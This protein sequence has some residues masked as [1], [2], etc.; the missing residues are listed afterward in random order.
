MT[1]CAISK[2]P[3][4]GVLLLDKP[5]G[6]TSNAALQ[7]VKRCCTAK[8]GHVGARSARQRFVPVCLGEAANSPPAL[9]PTKATMPRFCWGGH[10]TGDTEVK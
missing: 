10:P 9:V 5:V 7:R 3:I 2:R 6:I 1:R 8:A 4:D